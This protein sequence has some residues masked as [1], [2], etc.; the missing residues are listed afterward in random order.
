MF[1]TMG[2]AAPGMV[3]VGRMRMQLCQLTCSKRLKPMRL[4]AA[5]LFL[6]AVFAGSAFAQAG[7]PPS[8]PKPKA[9]APPSAA[10]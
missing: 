3:A 2:P 5:A 10:G 8:V 9:V 7:G 4:S 6:A 1:W